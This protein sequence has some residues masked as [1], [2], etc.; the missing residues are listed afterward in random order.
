[1][2]VNPEL[3]VVGLDRSM[4]LAKICVSHGKEVGCADIVDVPLRTGSADVV[5]CVAVLH[6]ISTGLRRVAAAHE[7]L[8]VVKP[9]GLVFVQV[10]FCLIRG[11]SPNGA[12]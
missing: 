10:R 6:H 2:A 3:V 7:L 11:G 1:M 4:E 9:G 5:L 8:R 12:E